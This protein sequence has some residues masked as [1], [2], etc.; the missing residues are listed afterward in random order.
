[1][2]SSFQGFWIPP[3]VPARN[4]IRWEERCCT[5]VLQLVAS[6]R[7]TSMQL[8]P[9][10]S[11]L[12]VVPHTYGKSLSE[13]SCP[14]AHCAGHWS[15]DTEPARERVKETVKEPAYALALQT[16][17]FIILSHSHSWKL[18]QSKSWSCLLVHTGAGEWRPG[19]FTGVSG[20]ISVVSSIC[21]LACSRDQVPQG[22]FGSHRSLSARFQCHIRPSLCQPE[23]ALIP[24]K[25]ESLLQGGVQF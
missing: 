23:S 6:Q 16:E 5:K 9:V 19:C 24:R 14:A 10:H 1:M 20:C 21:S 25:G 3:F 17:W 8:S 2:N 18:F 7:A 15:T 13:R 11:S 12:A 4:S 22:R